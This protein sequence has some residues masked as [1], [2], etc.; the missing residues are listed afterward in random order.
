MTITWWPG[1]LRFTL[2]KP[3]GILR[4]MRYAFVFVSIVA[5]WLALILLALNTK[6][7]G[8]F[9]A[10]IVLVLTVTLFLIGFKRGR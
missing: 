9:L 6:V 10:S 4:F 2:C 1:R 7:N 3:F 5:I 8:L